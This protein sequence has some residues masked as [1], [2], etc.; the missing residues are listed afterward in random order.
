[1]V[2][3]CRKIPIEFDQ[4]ISRSTAQYRPSDPIFAQ[5]AMLA[6]NIACLLGDVDAAAAEIRSVAF[7]RWLT[8]TSQWNR[9]HKR[10]HAGF[11][12]PGPIESFR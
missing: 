3:F 11:H 4:K 9:Y 10:R 6:H 1:M 7:P 12:S 2:G 5:E 8:L